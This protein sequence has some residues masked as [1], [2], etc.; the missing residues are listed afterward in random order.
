MLAIGSA[1]ADLWERA[2]DRRSFL[3][4]AVLLAIPDLAKAQDRIVRTS[5]GQVRVE[6]IARGLAHPWGLA[7]LPDGRMLVSERPG[8]LRVV[9]RGGGVSTPLVGVPRVFARGQGGLLD[10][11]LA[12]DFAASRWVYLSYAESGPGGAGTAVSRGRL[13]PAGLQDVQVIF[14][15]V[16]KVDGTNHFGSRLVF[17]RDG[18]LFV[19]LGDRFKFNP[20]QDLASHLGKIVRI[21]PD[22]TAPADNPFAHTQ[23]ARPEIWS[24]GHRN[25]QGATLHPTTGM[26]WVHEMGPRGGDELN[27]PQAGRNYGWP[28]VSWGR[29]YDGRAIPSPASRPDIA[30]SLRQWSPVIAPSGMTFYTG[31]LFPA[32]RGSLLIGGLVARGVV[33][34]SLQGQ[35]VTGEERIS[36]GQRIRDVRQG[37]DGAVYV[38]TD[39]TSGEI[40]RL[41]P[42]G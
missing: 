33:R 12:P 2:M 11:A 5:S 29:H 19:T 22:G 21:N 6:T 31:S 4:L 28:L 27:V 30:G 39:E 17:S 40:L 32:W 13:G 36:L 41:T 42:A 16:P 26:L 18:R 20:A 25:V 9:S 7:F 15:Q 24:Y 8:R 14:R 23:G 3:A 35:Q 1:Q 34:V 10:V 37:P 38:L